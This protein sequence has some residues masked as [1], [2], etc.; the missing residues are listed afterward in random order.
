MALE[1][2]DNI[3][4]KIIES[5]LGRENGT[6]ITPENHQAFALALLDYIRSVEL[7]SGST[8]IGIAREDTVPIQSND[9]NACY[10]A[11]VAQDRIATFANFH[12][13]DGHP[14][15]VTTSASEAKFVILLWNREFWD[16]VEMNGNII[17]QAENA[18]F[19]YQFTIKK[20]YNS[21]AEM[22]ADA[23]SPIGIDGKPL[24]IGD[25]VTVNSSNES[26]NGIYSWNNGTW[27]K[28]TVMNFMMNKNID[29]GSS[30][31]SGKDKIQLKR[32]SKA[33]WEQNNP[34]LAAGEIGIETESG[35]FKIGD[36]VK[37]WKEIEYRGNKL[38]NFLS[39]DETIG[40]SSKGAREHL[41]SK[42]DI[43]SDFGTG[44]EK[45]VSQSFLTE[46][47]V[48]V[49]ATKFAPSSSNKTP[50][51]FR[52]SIPESLRKPGL[53]ITYFYGGE[54]TF[55]QFNSEDVSQWR[56]SGNWKNLK[57]NFEV[58]TFDG[59]INSAFSVKENQASNADGDII[60]DISRHIFLQKNNGEFYK[61]Y[62]RSS[63]YN[64]E[65][66]SS[67][68]SGVLFVSR[69][70]IVYSKGNSVVFQEIKTDTVENLETDS[71]APLA[72]SQ[73]VKLKEL[74][75][76]GY[77]FFGVVKVNTPLSHHESKGFYILDGEGLY[78]QL[79][80]N[81]GGCPNLSKGECGICV[82]EDNAT[83]AYKALPF[84]SKV[85]LE[86]VT[87]SIENLEI[88]KTKVLTEDAYNALR[89]A[90]K[91]EADRFYFTIE[92][93]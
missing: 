48:V 43:A 55:E 56:I 90:E 13:S 44:T 60:Y 59:F 18:N 66:N 37:R 24:R 2:Y 63:Q 78:T 79:P 65:D 84:L 69:G 62:G 33:K 31:D 82:T 53:I 93:E 39:D 5:L 87:K 22:N 67:I 40:L 12:N 8:L 9:A 11:A 49:D 19:Y 71:S 30:S 46:S 75:N 83:Y 38:T 16:F 20:S 34:I 1:S 81:G 42:D 36:G 72:A 76:D 45:V 6:E 21:A 14:I 85:A 86:D 64:N 17:S 25:I 92:D 23:A 70:A 68:L 50:A 52:S 4:Q 58:R 57:Q 3:K 74:I 80:F 89:N 61:S 51:T 88:T 28:Q 77:K 32:D 35:N 15:T 47:S 91:L 41:V 54:W 27:V 73:G 7:I 10:I 29:G 26:E